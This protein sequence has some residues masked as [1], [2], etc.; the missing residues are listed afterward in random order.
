MGYL[1]LVGVVLDDNGYRDLSDNLKYID[2]ALMFN[3]ETLFST[4]VS[5]CYVLKRL[6]IIKNFDSKLFRFLRFPE[7]VFEDLSYSD[8]LSNK[9]ETLIYAGIYIYI[10]YVVY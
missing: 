1:L 2:D 3:G 9:Y 5:V 4:R 8:I 10:F 7:G 6:G